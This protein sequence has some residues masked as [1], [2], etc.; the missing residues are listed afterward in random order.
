M[1]L[2]VWRLCAAGLDGARSRRIVLFR[3]LVADET[4]IAEIDAARH[5]A[6]CEPYRAATERQ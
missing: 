1:E 5:Y 4:R 2:G 6:V 3:T